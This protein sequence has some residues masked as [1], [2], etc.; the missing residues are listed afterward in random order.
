LELEYR[1]GNFHRAFLIFGHPHNDGLQRCT[2]L[3]Y[4]EIPCL[5]RRN[6]FGT[7]LMISS[8]VITSSS[9][10]CSVWSRCRVVATGFPLVASASVDSSFFS[11]STV[12]SE[13][14]FPELLMQRS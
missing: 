7:E 2:F 9:A 10:K 14:N 4:N 8:E 3:I 5:D 13:A 11:L 12:V 6:T 1:G